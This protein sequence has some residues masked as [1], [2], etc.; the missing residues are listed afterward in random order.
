MEY[1]PFALLSLIAI[2]LRLAALLRQRFGL[3]SVEQGAAL[4][5]EPVKC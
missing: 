3:P 1:L 2:P 4:D 5:R